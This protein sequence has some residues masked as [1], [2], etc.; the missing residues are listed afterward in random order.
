MKY[1]NSALRDVTKEFENNSREALLEEI[2]KLRKMINGI[3]FSVENAITDLKTENS[4][5]S[6]ALDALESGLQRMDGLETSEF[7]NIN[8]NREF[9][10]LGFIN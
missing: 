10:V 5:G 7:F 2:T 1:E 6:I 3:S 8:K 4:D 9:E